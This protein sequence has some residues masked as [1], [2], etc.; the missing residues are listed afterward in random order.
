MP[1]T[2]LGLIPQSIVG[3]KAVLAGENSG[4]IELPKDI[5]ADNQILSDVTYTFAEDGSVKAHSLNTYVGRTEIIFRPLFADSTYGRDPSTIIKLMLAFYGLNG[6]GKVVKVSD[7]HQVGDPFSVEFETSVGNF[8]TFEPKGKLTLPTGLNM[9]NLPEMGQLATADSRKTSLDVGA[10]RLRENITIEIPP[11]VTMV[12]PPRSV[13]VTT[14]VGSF[15][16]SPEMKDGRLHI[17]R[18]LLITKDS[19]EPAEYPVFKELVNKLVESHKL[20]IEYTADASLSKGKN[21]DRKAEDKSN[22]PKSL[23]DRMIEAMGVFG[24][25]DPLKASEVRELEARITSNENDEDS[26]KKLIRHYAHYET[27]QTPGVQ[28]AF[29]KHR[30]WMIQNRPRL[31][32]EQVL[33]WM[34]PSLPTASREGLKNAWLASV[35]KAKGDSIVR[36]NAIEFLKNYFPADAAKLI[37]EGSAVDPTNYKF[38]LMMTEIILQDLKKDSTEEQ[39]RAIAAKLLGP[40]KLALGLIKKERSDERDRDRRDLLKVLS[41]AAVAANDL[42]AAESF[43]TELILDFGQSVDSYEYGDS[44]HLGNVTLGRAQ[45]RR[46]NIEKA[47]EYLLVAIRAPLRQP[48]SSLF[49]IDMRLAK[50]LYE[51]GVKAEVLEFLNLC[52]ELQTKKARPKLYE[53]EIRALKLWQEQIEKGVKPSFD[54]GAP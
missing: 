43:A 25:G 37:D 11:T 12:A 8:T 54:F 33:S 20:E 17:S 27:K 31:G 3:K 44:T 10:T 50:E 45:L 42:D 18:E 1:N 47:K 32:D 26:R 35:A 24:G 13:N 29:L 41:S 40:G 19:I 36:L 22:E 51:K 14:A 28:S 46:G 52:I 16:I 6:D 30:I 34:R 49:S 2:R 21:K 39:K 23:A 4:L 5:P 7:P 53:D 38:P 9:I 48:K 15:T